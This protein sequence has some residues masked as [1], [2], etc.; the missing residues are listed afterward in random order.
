[1][2]TSPPRQCHPDFSC[3][4]EVA[5]TLLRRLQTAQLSSHYT[6][7]TLDGPQITSDACADVTTPTFVCAEPLSIASCR[8]AASLSPPTE[9]LPKSPLLRSAYASRTCGSLLHHRRH[10]S[11]AIC[12]RNSHSHAQRYQKIVRRRAFY[13]ATGWSWRSSGRQHPEMAARA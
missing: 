13:P 10:H 6:E 9:H 12:R 7:A 3:A 5:A 1:M 8:A 11:S 4:A 2:I